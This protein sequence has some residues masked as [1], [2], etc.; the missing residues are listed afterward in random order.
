MVE[1]NGLY[2]LL[3]DKLIK[4]YGKWLGFLCGSLPRVVTLSTIP[5]N[6]LTAINSNTVYEPVC[7]PL[8]ET[9]GMGNVL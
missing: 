6:Y 2:R 8:M 9:K 7:N 1:V 3:A 4:I 5:I